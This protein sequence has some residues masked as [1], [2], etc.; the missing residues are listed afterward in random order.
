MSLKLAGLLAR[1]QS[2]TE[3]T[4]ARTALVHHIVAS[5]HCTAQ[6]LDFVLELSGSNQTE[7]INSFHALDWFEIGRACNSHYETDNLQ[8]VRVAIST[9]VPTDRH[10]HK[11]FCDTMSVAFRSFTH[12]SG[13]HKYDFKDGH[14]AE[15]RYIVWNRPFQ[16]QLS[17]SVQR[18]VHDRERTSPLGLLADAR[19]P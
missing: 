4:Q 7:L 16:E 2:E 13:K 11:M 14:Y 17:P 9:V 1:G 6:C 12:M 8:V 19:Q 5:A 3:T 15:P 10:S 18:F